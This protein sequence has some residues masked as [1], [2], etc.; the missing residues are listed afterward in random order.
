MTEYSYQGKELTELSGKD[1]GERN[2][3]LQQALAAYQKNRYDMTFL[4][5]GKD[6]DFSVIGS[7]DFTGTYN[8]RYQSEA[9]QYIMQKTLETTFAK[10]NAALNSRLI[11]MLGIPDDVNSSTFGINSA[12]Q[13]KEAYRNIVLNAVKN[14]SSDS[15]WLNSLDDTAKMTLLDI[16]LEK[17]PY[18]TRQLSDA[19]LKLPE[20]DSSDYNLNY[21][22]VSQLSKHLLST[23]SKAEAANRPLSLPWETKAEALNVYAQ[24]NGENGL[25]LPTFFNLLKTADD[26]DYGSFSRSARMAKMTELAEKISESF[27]F[28]HNF[29]NSE[30]RLI[31]A[32]WAEMLPSGDGAQKFFYTCLYKMKLP[33]TRNFPQ[34][35]L[36]AQAY[37]NAVEEVRAQRLLDDFDKYKRSTLSPDEM[38]LLIRHRP[39]ELAGYKNFSPE[40]QLS[41]L[42]QS[43]FNL[44][45]IQRLKLMTRY[46]SS[47]KKEEHAYIADRDID[48][49]LDTALKMKTISPEMK[50]FIHELAPFVERQTVLY[51][52]NKE[53]AAL[54]LQK[55]EQ[56]NKADAEIREYTETQS[57]LNRLIS[58]SREIAGLRTD[59]ETQLSDASLEKIVR[60]AI[61][62]KSP[63]TVEYEKQSGLSSLFSGKKEKER[64]QKTEKLVQ[65]LNALLPDLAKH[66]DI[67]DK[68]EPALVSQE[69]FRAFST[70]YAEADKRQQK[71]DME[72]NATSPFSLPSLQEA[73]NDYEKRKPD[74]KLARLAENLDSR[75]KELKQKARENLSFAF[76]GQE[77]T[78][79]SIFENQKKAVRKVYKEKAEEMKKR[80]K[81]AVKE[82]MGDRG[83]YAKPA[84]ED[85][86]KSGKKLSKETAGKVLKAMRDK[87][88]YET[89]AKSK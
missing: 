2:A 48:F 56:K 38:R 70:L 52:Q 59:K 67:F 31:P 76:K 89:L 6:V 54:I 30:G 64:Q 83:V 37:R 51:Q 27:N 66:K 39:Q 85:D 44:S 14:F 88:L 16:G 57:D 36:N 58:L 80:L 68:I 45:E 62:G 84:L 18:W 46:I 26:R 47:V 73:I 35:S 32:N 74:E 53:K 19:H 33:E 5:I 25:M 24:T 8:D 71:A 81:D 15:F 20:K 42:S 28:K 43:D 79:E 13:N 12:L 65:E 69:S 61:A 23:A 40:T 82:E 75:T 60:N 34:N 86:G 29:V 87:K 72:Y 22:Q 3:Y 21:N 63:Q 11:S 4:P 49:L 1:F 9:L 10:G 17:D 77:F 55:Q 50:K 41:L 7:L 78:G